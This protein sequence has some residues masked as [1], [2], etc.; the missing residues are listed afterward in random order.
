MTKLTQRKRLIPNKQ[1][2]IFLKKMEM[3]KYS[4]NILKSTFM[5][6]YRRRK[7]IQ[8][9][10]NIENEYEGRIKNRTI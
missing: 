6:S 4:Q 10:F 1:E 7:K 5:S 8:L 3:I 9:F 2:M